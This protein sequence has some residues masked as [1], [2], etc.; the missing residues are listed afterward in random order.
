[1]ELYYQIT[2]GI[3][4]VV[5]ICLLYCSFSMN[6]GYKNLFN[7]EENSLS[8]EDYYEYKLKIDICNFI[9][10]CSI[11]ILFIFFISSIVII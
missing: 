7:K 3:F 1:M 2:I 10:Y 8:K 4:L 9:I 11:I 6:D 5:I